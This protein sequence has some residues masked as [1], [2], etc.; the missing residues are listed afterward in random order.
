MEKLSG[1]EVGPVR[2]PLEAP[3]EKKLDDI[4]KMVTELGIFKWK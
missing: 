2:A 1:V 4:M 3:S